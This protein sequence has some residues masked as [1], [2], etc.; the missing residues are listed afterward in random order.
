M[1]VEGSGSANKNAAFLEANNQA[2]EQAKARIKANPKDLQGLL[3]LTITDGMESDYDALII[4]KQLDGLKMM[5][6]AET[7]A[8]LV[9]SIDPTEQD[10]NVALGNEQLRNRM[11]AELQKNVRVV[12]RVARRPHTRHGPNAVGGGTRTLSETICE[13]DAGAGL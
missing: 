8:N 13:G 7:E 10:A 3:V 11:F 12:W 9:L 1:G 5:R 4:K 6:S 2:R